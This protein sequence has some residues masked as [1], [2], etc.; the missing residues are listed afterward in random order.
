MPEAG[1]KRV[2]VRA[3]ATGP[4]IAVFDT[5][6]SAV[7][8]DNPAAFQPV[9][10]IGVELFRAAGSRVTMDRITVQASDD[11]PVISRSLDFDLGP[12]PIVG[13]D[14]EEDDDDDWEGRYFEVYILLGN[15][16]I[17]GWVL[18]GTYLESYD[19]DVDHPPRIDE[20]SREFVRFV[21]TTS[22]VL[23]A[24]TSLSAGDRIIAPP[25]Q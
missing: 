11:T 4:A 25:P 1:N 7:T 9:R 13:C 16:A 10:T 21:S 14:D 3:S 18:D 20:A 17:R 19:Q 5:H 2:I 8:T 22:P 6:T 24:A 23:I 12:P 15:T